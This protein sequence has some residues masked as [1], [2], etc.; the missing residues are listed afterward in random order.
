MEMAGLSAYS[1]HH[2]PAPRHRQ[3]KTPGQ[4]HPFSMSVAR[5]TARSASRPA[6][7]ASSHAPCN[8]RRNSS[9]PFTGTAGSFRRTEQP[10]G[11]DDIEQADVL[12]R[13]GQAV[14]GDWDR[15]YHREVLLFV[16]REVQG[17]MG[18]GAVELIRFARPSGADL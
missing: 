4:Q 13:P 1:R 2:P 9:P 7:A 15:D 11:L 16:L 10:H 8:R 18:T 3:R 6:S 14:A 5:L 12:R 17:G